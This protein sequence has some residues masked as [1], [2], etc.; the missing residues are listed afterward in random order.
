MQHN[1]HSH[2]GC[3]HN[4]SDGEYMAGMLADYGYTVTTSETLCSRVSC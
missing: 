3:S 4:N 1:V 2:A